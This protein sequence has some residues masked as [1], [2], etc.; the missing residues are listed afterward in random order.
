MADQK[1]SVEKAVHTKADRRRVWRRL[2]TPRQ[3][4]ECGGGCS[5]QGRLGGQYEE[6]C[7]HQ[8][9]QEESEGKAVHTNADRRRIWRRL[10][11]L[12]Q[13]GSRV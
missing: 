7:S 2:F 11:T 10:F 1:E 12:Q 4:G 3:T 5:Y 6:D 8:G 9:R 13:I